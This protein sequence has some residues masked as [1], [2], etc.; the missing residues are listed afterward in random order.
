MKYRYVEFSC[1]SCSVLH[2]MELDEEEDEDELDGLCPECEADWV[3]QTMSCHGL[4]AR[5]K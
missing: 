1:P 5:T 3:K 2:E 4:S